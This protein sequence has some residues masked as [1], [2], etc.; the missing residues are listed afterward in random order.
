MLSNLCVVCSIEEAGFRTFGLCAHFVE[1]SSAV[2]GT[3]ILGPTARSLLEALG[4]VQSGQEDPMAKIGQRQQRGGYHEGM[5]NLRIRTRV[6]C[7][8]ISSEPSDQRTNLEHLLLGWHVRVGNNGA[9][10]QQF[11]FPASYKHWE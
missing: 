8:V 1:P 11:L 10:Q 7:S 9:G 2:L 6:D 3:C 4:V 5:V